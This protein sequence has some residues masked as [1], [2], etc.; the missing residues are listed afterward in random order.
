MLERVAGF[1]PAVAGP[2]VAYGLRSQ[3]RHRLGNQVASYL[4]LADQL[5]PHD[6]DSA[7]RV[8]DLVNPLDALERSSIAPSLPLLIAASPSV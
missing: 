8:R 6:A 5:E 3:R 7:K 2:L 4:E 1:V